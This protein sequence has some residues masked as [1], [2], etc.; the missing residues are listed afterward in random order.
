MSARAVRGPA[1]SMA[2]MRWARVIIAVLIAIARPAP[3]Q[4]DP[5]AVFD[6][7]W[8]LVREHFY[9]PAMHGVD[10]EAVREERLPRAGASASAAELSA[11]INEALGA[12]GASHTRHY[13]PG[14]VEY[15]EL[16]DVFHPG[17]LEEHPLLPPG[18]V[19]YVGI[20]VRT[21]EIGGRT[22]VS[23]VYDGGPAAGALV[24][25]GDEVVEAAGGA[26]RGAETFAE[27]AGEPT[28]LLVRRDG[29]DE[30]PRALTVVP[31]RIEP[32][33]LF[34]RSIGES[35]REIRHGGRRIGYVRVRSYAAPE[36]HEAVMTLARGRFADAD[37][38]IL[39]LRGGWGGAQAEYMSLVNPVAPTMRWKPREGEWREW[40]GSWRRPLVLLIDG[41]SRSGK[42]MLAYAYKK[43]GLA[44]L[45]GERTAGAVLGGR[46][47]MLGDG[48][49]LYVAVTDVLVDGERLEGV[50]VAPDVEVARELPYSGGRDPQLAAAIEEAGRMVRAAGSPQEP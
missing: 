4:G 20:G 33:E 38:L 26:W 42:E 40:P 37:A 10:W 46:A 7:A 43:H 29:P 6:E 18:P 15:Y 14:E 44:R 1:G 2:P 30:E 28:V 39:D 49:L 9:D 8:G 48:S 36:Y 50:G 5:A 32:G 27:R 25:V 11:A 22:F 35:A 47:F 17:G 45:V 21:E 12:L 41:G 24:R 19:G 34:L 23:D 13:H 3:G 16:L 31:E